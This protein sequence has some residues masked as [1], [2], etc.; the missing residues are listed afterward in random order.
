MAGLKERWK[1]KGTTEASA[2]RFRNCE[3]TMVR[4]LKKRFK[5]RS[6]FEI[7]RWQSGKFSHSIEKGGNEGGEEGVRRSMGA[8]GTQIHN[9]QRCHRRTINKNRKS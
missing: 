1:R 4:P 6:A 9:V 7:E 2:G 3:G 8:A 5:G